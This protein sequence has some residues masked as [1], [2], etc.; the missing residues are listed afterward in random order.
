M[1]GR[2]TRVFTSACA[3]AS[4]AVAACGSPQAAPAPA[5][6]GAAAPT[7]PAVAGQAAAP[8]NPNATVIRY[9]LWD[10]GQQPAY[11]QCATKF[12]EQNP[13]IAIK[14]E[15][16]GWDDYWSS[17]QTGFVSGNAPD[18]FTDHLAKYPEFAAKGQVV[19]IQ[20]LVEKDKVDTKAYIGALPDLW[21]R[22]GKR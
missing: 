8:A 15:Q 1:L 6:G 11:Q 12:Q 20:P 22:E 17:L 7:T 14:F 5:S 18:V 16:V 21:G 4:L 10:S 2:H 9:A 19:D 3:A 13:N